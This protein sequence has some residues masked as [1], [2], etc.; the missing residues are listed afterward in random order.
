MADNPPPGSTPRTL[1]ESIAAAANRPPEAATRRVFL[2]HPSMVP[3]YAEAA[4]SPDV[5]IRVQPRLDGPSYPL[6][7][8]LK[9][10]LR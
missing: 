3:N 10:P 1:L 7:D 6:A 9:N 2:I 5:D 4:E 8:W